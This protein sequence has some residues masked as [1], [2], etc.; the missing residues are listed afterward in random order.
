M[1]IYIYTLRAKTISMRLQS[2]EKVRCN[3]FAY[4]YKM[5]SFWPGDF[6]ERGYRLTES[7]A[8]RNSENA[9][10]SPDRSGYAVLCSQNSDYE[11]MPVYRNITAGLWYDSDKFPGEVVGFARSSGSKVEVSSSTSWSTGTYLR[12][13]E[14]I[15]YR[16]RSHIKDGVCSHEREDLPLVVG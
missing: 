9:F 1:G 12:G 16:G 15:P 5:E 4:A 7:N 13:E 3:L 8:Q 6:G 10:R 14:W 2:G 11:D